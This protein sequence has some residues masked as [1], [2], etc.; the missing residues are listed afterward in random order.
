MKLFPLAAEL[1]AH[2]LFPESCPVC[3]A[4]GRAICPECLRGLAPEG[5][6]PRCL[7]C[8]GPAPCPRHGNRYKISA[9][10][11][12]EGKPRDVLLAAKYG[13][14]GAL[15]RALGKALVPL[16]DEEG[17]WAI[18]PIPPH[19]RLI[20]FPQGDDHLSWMARG[21]AEASG[22]PVIRPLAWNVPVKPQKEQKVRRARKEM[23]KNCFSC[24]P[25]PL[26][27][28]LLLDDVCTTGT[29][30]LRAADALYG[31]G[32]KEVR[33]LCWSVAEG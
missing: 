17:P 8:G 18:T 10:C 7:A 23:P 16:I 1:A 12:H 31:A 19:D 13:S 24:V 22:F 9:L 26:E 2:L 25:V 32:V 6:L 28:I 20:L 27:R 3:G 4:L 5:L 21:L 33:G 14:R 11:R 30:L 29:T 15:A